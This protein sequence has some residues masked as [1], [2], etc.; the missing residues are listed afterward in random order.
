L[1][2]YLC[3]IVITFRSFSTSPNSLI[4]VP[5]L[6]P[7]L[8]CEYLALYQSGA[9]RTPQ[10]TDIPGSYQ[11]V[12]LFIIVYFCHLHFKCYPGSPLHTPPAQLPNLPT[13]TSWPWNSPVLGHIIFARPRDSPPND[14][15]LGH[16]LLHLQLETRALG[17]LVSSYCCSCY[18]VAEPFNSLDTFS[19]SS[20]GGRCVPSN[21]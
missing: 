7:I 1:I 2:L 8:G 4:E 12:L 11:E 13:L 20:I 21:R 9:G 10:E 14:G 6:S 16:L 15:Q 18:R 17:V 3:G 5:R 19:R